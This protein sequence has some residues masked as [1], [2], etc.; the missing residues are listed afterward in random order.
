MSET[1]KNKILDL[2]GLRQLRTSQK[3]KTIV[4]C[5]GCYDILQSGHAVFFNQCKSFGDILVVGVG[6]DKVIEQL[7]GPGRPV[8]PENNR[9]YLV[10]A[11]E[12]VTYAVLND[13]E[14][15]EGKI[16]FAHIL[17]AL[18][19]NIF[20]INDDDS[21]VQYKKDLCKKLKITPQ[22]V[23]R[24]VPP[25]LVPTSTTN[26]INKINYAYRA[27]LRIDFAGG[28]ADVPYIMYGKKGYVSNVAIKPLIEYKSGKF[29]FSGYPRGSGLSTSTAAKLLE[30]ISAKNYNV[31]NKTLQQ[32]G[33]DLFNLENKELQW[34]IGR[35]DQYSIVYGGFQCFEFGQDYAK[36]LEVNITQE[37]L[38]ELRHQMLLI[39]TG[40]SR[41]AQ[42]AVED[43]Y[44]NHKTPEGIDA[45][46]KLSKYGRDFALALEKR[47]FDLCAKIV[48]DNWKAQKQLA[49]SCTNEELEEMYSFA[50]ANGA[51]GAKL[52]G[53]GG[54]G[55]FLFMT[56]DPLK[57]K[58]AMK[59][60]FSG[61]F[62]IDFE[63]E[64]QD[65]K[66]LNKI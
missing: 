63:F 32:V 30:M 31:D 23:S 21:A 34:F 50:M 35:Q 28:W 59:K 4:F 61:C 5:S 64:Y 54:G 49:P 15:G 37:T 8:N 16:D 39:H 25:E 27:P 62:E 18:R 66:T 57:L 12:D 43:V 38:E 46:E 33:E 65:I 26:I 10:A 55:A 40:V 22:T 44:K 29:N 9:V 56:D 11:M 17:E 47:D 19:P 41:N 13:H 1:A 42:T 6:R 24:S 52:C 7:K 14:V 3:D 20:I 60:Q 45:L 51:K 36:P 48:D 58:R 2:E 53:A